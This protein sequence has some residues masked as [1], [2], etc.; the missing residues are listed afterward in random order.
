[1]KIFNA[2]MIR[3]AFGLLFT[4]LKSV[5]LIRIEIDYVIHSPV[6]NVSIG[7]CLEILKMMR[8][9]FLVF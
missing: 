7:Q 2:I 5:Y 1:M 9:F 3:P 4:R 8:R 6:H